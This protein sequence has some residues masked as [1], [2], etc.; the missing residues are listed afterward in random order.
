MARMEVV[1][2]SDTVLMTAQATGS[3]TTY[4]GRVSA[5]KA[6]ASATVLDLLQFTGRRNNDDD[7]DDGDNLMIKQMW[8]CSR[9]SS[10]CSSSSSS[11]DGAVFAAT[12]FAERHVLQFWFYRRGGAI[13]IIFLFGG[14]GLVGSGPSIIRPP[15]PP[16]CDLDCSHNAARCTTTFV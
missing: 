8:C 10:S 11:S 4:F 13:V 14:M 1:V 6:G 2:V 7:D 3:A 9:Y 5:T 15:S 12:L 16:Y